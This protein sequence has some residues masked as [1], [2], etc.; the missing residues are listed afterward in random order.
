MFGWS[1]RIAGQRRKRQIVAEIVGGRVMLKCAGKWGLVLLLA[2]CSPGG[3]GDG[4]KSKPEPLRG[5][6]R[7]LGGLANFAVIIDPA[8]GQ[9][10]IEAAARGLCV[11]APICTVLGWTDAA[12]VPGRLPMLDREA[13]AQAFAYNLNRNSSF[14]RVLWDCARWPQAADRCMAKFDP[15]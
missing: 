13:A 4:A 12:Q 10:E 11:D 1:E 9:A 7:D 15:E 5:K 6:P 8:A 3:A 2:A 14:E